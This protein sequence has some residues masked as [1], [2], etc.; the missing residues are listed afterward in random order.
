MTAARPRPSPRADAAAP[1]D[2][3][4][5]AACRHEN[6]ELF[7]PI[8]TSGPALDQI[9]EAKAVCARC[10]V[11]EICLQVALD[12]GE[13]EGIWGGTT[14][15]ERRELIRRRRRGVQTVPRRRATGS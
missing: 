10:P 15:Q 11:R 7:F 13:D 8:G 5:Q 1:A 4:E 3:R 12:H 2:W 6:P 9:D 14:P